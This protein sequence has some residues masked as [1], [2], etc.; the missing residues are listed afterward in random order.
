M[1]ICGAVQYYPGRMDVVVNPTLI[2]E[3]LSKSTGGL[4]KGEKFTWY[5]ALD[6]LQDYLLIDQYRVHVDWCH[7]LANGR[8][9]LTEY[10]SLDDALS[11]KSISVEL[12]IRLLYQ[13]VD[14]LRV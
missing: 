2:A 10:A 6:S 7:K 9:L 1:V 13:R 12:P 11:P 4:D 8:W 3:V 14:W 5:R